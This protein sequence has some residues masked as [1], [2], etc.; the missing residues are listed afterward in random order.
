MKKREGETFVYQKTTASCKKSER[1]KK[2][3]KQFFTFSSILKSRFLDGVTMNGGRTKKNKE[4]KTHA[5]EI[6]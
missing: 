6:S 4:R 3:K 2:T 1:K 5:N